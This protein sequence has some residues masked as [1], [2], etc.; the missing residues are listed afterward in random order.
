MRVP[1]LEQ[2]RVSLDTFD[3]CHGRWG[4]IERARGEELQ[5]PNK[6]R[7]PPAPIPAPPTHNPQ[8]QVPQGTIQQCLTTAHY[9]A[10]RGF[11]M[12]SCFLCCNGLTGHGCLESEMPR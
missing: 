11:L 8:T 12:A 3:R 6:A 10:V 7:T 5:S 2:L 9:R 4:R 1:I